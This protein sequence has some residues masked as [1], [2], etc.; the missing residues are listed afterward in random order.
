MLEWTICNNCGKLLDNSQDKCESCGENVEKI[1]MDYLQSQLENLKFLVGSLSI[2]K[3]LCP[4]IDSN[5]DRIIE[6]DLFDWLSYLG[7]VDGKLTDNE[8]EFIDTLL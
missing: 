2:F 8:K 3:D 4:S 5:L 6:D 7:Y 1:H